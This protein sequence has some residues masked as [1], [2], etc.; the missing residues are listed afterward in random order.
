MNKNLESAIAMEEFVRGLKT[1]GYPRYS[2]ENNGKSLTYRNSGFVQIY[3]MPDWEELRQSLAEY[4]W[5]ETDEQLEEALH[6]AISVYS[7]ASWG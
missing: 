7:V 2:D 3:R 5:V 4:D 6:D 1:D